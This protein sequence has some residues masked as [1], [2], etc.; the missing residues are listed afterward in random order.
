[1]SD[2]HTVARRQLTEAGHRYTRGRQSLVD[3]LAEIGAP[4]TMPMILQHAPDLVQS[5]LYRNLAVMEQSGVVTRVDVGDTKSY[6]ELSELVTD[7]HHHHLVCKDCSAVVDVN[8]PAGAERS[9]E[10]ALGEAAREAGFQL[11]EHRVD[12]IGSCADCSSD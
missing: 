4:A 8:L 5:S 1:M 9:I 3:L 6:Y 2:L 11:A 7:D 12:L 10:R